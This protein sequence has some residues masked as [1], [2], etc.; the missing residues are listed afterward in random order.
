MLQMLQTVEKE[1]AKRATENQMLREQTRQAL[2]YI[3]QSNNR[4]DQTIKSKQFK[5]TSVTHIT[6]NTT[7]ELHTKI[8]A[9]KLSVE[10]EMAVDDQDEV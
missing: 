8:D 3:V 2:D 6:S 7:I 9:Q 4:L 10:T 1:N 5:Y